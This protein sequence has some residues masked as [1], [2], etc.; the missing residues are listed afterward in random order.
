MTGRAAQGTARSLAHG[1]FRVVGAAESGRLAGRTRYCDRLH[2]VPP[3]RESRAYAAAVRRIC[4]TERVIAVLP[5]FD[6]LQ[7]VLLGR[8]EAVGDAILVGPSLHELKRLCD[9]VGLLEVAAAAGVRHP[10]TKVVSGNVPSSGL[11]PLPGYVKV[12]TSMYDGRPAGRP[13][14]V[15]D[16]RSR[17]HLLARLLGRGDVVVVQEEVDGRQWRYDFVR[18]RRTSLEL[19]SIQLSD[20]P[21]RVG[22]S[23]AL[24]FRELPPRLAALSRSLLDVVGYVGAGSIQWIERDDGE[25]FV[26]DVNLRLPASVAG[27]MAAGFD[28]PLAT[29]ELAFGH[30]PAPARLPARPLRYVWFQGEAMA[31]RD[32]IHGTPVGRSPARIAGSIVRSALSPS[33]CLVPF[34]PTDPLPTL[35]AVSHV[36]RR[37]QSGAAA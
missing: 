9:K 2:R 26:H 4:D 28:M 14:R 7:A 23:T 31:L 29:V 11:P 20:W 19:A 30:E 24:E 32:A 16:P 36:V 35:A 18:G 10:V 22:Q 12:V 25:W 3:S 33:M 37:R 34:D 17:D 27:M 8:P 15:T 6:E 13:V 21:Y 1:G 5:L